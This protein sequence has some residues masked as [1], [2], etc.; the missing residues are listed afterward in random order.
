MTLHQMLKAFI[1]LKDSKSWF[2][3]SRWNEQHS[4]VIEM[5]DSKSWAQDSRFNEQL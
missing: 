2:N 4:V 1:D 5:N 3:G